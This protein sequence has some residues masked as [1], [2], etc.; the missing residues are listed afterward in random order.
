MKVGQRFLW[1]GAFGKFIGEI[2]SPIISPFETFWIKIYPLDEF[3]TE[4]QTKVWCLCTDCQ[5]FY[6][7]LH[8][9]GAIQE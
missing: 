4:I 6:S 7:I 9:Q 8:N 3:Q 2:I 5:K 1:E